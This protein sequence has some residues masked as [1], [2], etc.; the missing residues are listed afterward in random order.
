MGH[1]SH[2]VGDWPVDMPPVCGASSLVGFA[3]WLM[4]Y[5]SRGGGSSDKCIEQKY[6]L[7]LGCF[8]DVF[9]T[10]ILLASVPY[11]FSKPLEASRLAGF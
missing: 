5:V 10:H 3:W 6:L 4:P 8:R 1:Y 7:L 11:T 9:T 2:F